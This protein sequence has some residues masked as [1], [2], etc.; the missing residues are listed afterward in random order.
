MITI[1]HPIDF[2]ETYPLDRI[3]PKEQLLFFD[4]ET[5]GFSGDTS[6]LYLIGC[7]YHDGFGWKLIQWFADTRQAESEL[8]DAFFGF[9]K[10]FK[11]LIH[12]NGDRFDIP[13]LEKCCRRLGLS[14]SFEGM[15]SMDIYKKIRPYRKLLG[16]ESMKQKAIE[17]FLGI[18]R[19]DKYTGGQLIEVYRDYLHTHEKSLYDLLILHNEDDLKGMPAILPILSYADF[20]SSPLFPQ[21]PEL[22]EGDCTEPTDTPFLHLTGTASVSVPVPLEYSS[23]PVSL[24]LYEN[25][26]VCTIRLCRGCLKYFYPDYKDYYYLPFEDTAVHK[27]V[28]EYVDRSARKKATARTC[29]TKKE[30]LFLPQF[31]PFKDPSFREDY[32]SPLTYVLYDDSLFSQPQATDTYFS[33]LFCWLLEQ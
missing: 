7:V 31:G 15:E 14:H 4:I 11:T 24:E 6:Q 10:R 8:L 19:E 17:Q 30:G 32:K 25:K 21:A 26:A 3:G 9:V 2:P 28:G 12:F 5:T 20:F 23:G 18:S 13:Y 27:S 1:K 16:L 33:Q 29:Y 22:W